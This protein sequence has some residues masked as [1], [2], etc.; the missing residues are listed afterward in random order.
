LRTYYCYLVECADGSLY[1]G[2]TTDPQRRLRQHNAG[3]GAR[4]TKLHRPVK[5]VFI[6][7]QIDLSSAL[8][9]ER[10]IK[11]LP[12]PKKLELLRKD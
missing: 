12:R 7:E 4:Y 5:L 9:R 3:T 8:K 2:I 6:E 1:T 10:Q 11:R